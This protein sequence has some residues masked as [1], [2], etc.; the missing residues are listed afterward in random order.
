MSGPGSGVSAEL[1]EVVPARLQCQQGGWG[2]QG[3]AALC[4]APGEPGGSALPKR[5]ADKFCCSAIL[6]LL[7]VPPWK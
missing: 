1:D 2:W 4:A 3:H 6:V 5:E 7:P